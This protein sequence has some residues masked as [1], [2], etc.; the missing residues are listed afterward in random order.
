MPRDREIAALTGGAMVTWSTLSTTSHKVMKSLGV[1]GNLL[2]QAMMQ[3]PLATMTGLKQ[4]NGSTTTVCRTT[5]HG[6]ATTNGRNPAVGSITSLRMTSMMATRTT[7]VKRMPTRSVAMALGSHKL[8]QM[9]CSCNL[10]QNTKVKPMKQ[11]RSVM[12]NNNNLLPQVSTSLA[13]GDSRVKSHWSPMKR[14][15]AVG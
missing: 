10:G 12:K 8:G 5:R 13:P 15:K 14:S 1:H 2:L 9:I 7:T 3:G 6:M 4:T 11:F